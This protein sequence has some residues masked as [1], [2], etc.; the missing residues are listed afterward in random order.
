M[1]NYTLYLAQTKVLDFHQFTLARA[2]VMPSCPQ[3]RCPCGSPARS[4]PAAQGLLTCPGNNPHIE[5]MLGLFGSS[6]SVT[7]SVH[8]LHDKEVWLLQCIQSSADTGQQSGR[9]V[10]RKCG[11]TYS[12]MI[13]EYNAA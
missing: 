13:G 5:W 12:V 9:H 6:P 1:G 8:Y 3:L 10:Q 4:S 2:A 7:K 11:S